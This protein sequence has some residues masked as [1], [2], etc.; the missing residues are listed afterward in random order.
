MKTLLFPAILVAGVAVAGCHQ[1]GS[2]ADS[3]KPST[4]PPGASQGAPDQTATGQ[5][6]APG[7]AAVPAGAKVRRLVSRDRPKWPDPWP[8]GCNRAI[9]VA[10]DVLP[11]GKVESAWVTKSA[12]PDVDALALKWFKGAEFEPDPAA[13]GAETQTILVNWTFDAP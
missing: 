4:A 11:N 6:A 2:G 10:A 3:V 1:A 5:N 12:C 9:S 8:P 7:G 13:K